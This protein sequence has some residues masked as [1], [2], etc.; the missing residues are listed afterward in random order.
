VRLLF[1]R[2]ERLFGVLS[3]RR[4]ATSA[5]RVDPY[6]R[7]TGA[8]LLTNRSLALSHKWIVRAID[9]DHHAERSLRC[10]REDDDW[11]FR[12]DYVRW[13]TYSRRRCSRDCTGIYPRTAQHAPYGPCRSIRFRGPSADEPAHTGPGMLK[14]RAIALNRSVPV[15]VPLTKQASAPDHFSAGH[16]RLSLRCA[17]LD[18][19]SRRH[20]RHA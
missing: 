14:P 11:N 3:A 19:S 2:P 9:I 4:R 5:V 20:S 13:S 8:T 18:A 12:I 10:A 6:G 7:P 17:P 1:S 15:P 16:A